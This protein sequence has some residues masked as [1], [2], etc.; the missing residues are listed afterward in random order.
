MK[1]MFSHFITRMD[2]STQRFKGN[3]K[4]DGFD[5]MP[6]VWLCHRRFWGRYTLPNRY[7]EFSAS[8]VLFGNNC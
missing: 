3:V 4:V 8:K 1:A 5:Y 2:F 6:K 7:I